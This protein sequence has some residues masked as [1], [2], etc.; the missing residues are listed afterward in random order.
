M[1]NESNRRKVS[2]VTEC[3]KK[4]KDSIEEFTLTM[5]S[6]ASL[7]MLYLSG[8]DLITDGSLD[9]A[10]NNPGVFFGTVLSPVVIAGLI[11]TLDKNSSVNEDIKDVI[12]GLK[13]KT[14]VRK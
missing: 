4:V 12:N 9:V 6:I 3:S 13:P 14:R 10:N 8:F 11:K 7:G 2:S 1:Q 5:S